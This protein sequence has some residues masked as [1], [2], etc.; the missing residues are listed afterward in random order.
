MEK[1]RLRREGESVEKEQEKKDKLVD[2]NEKIFD[3]FGNEVVVEK[4][5]K[6]SDKEKKREIKKLEKLLREGKKKGILTDTEMQ[7]IEEKLDAL[8]DQ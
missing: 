6:L 5:V 4:E 3:S 1:G 7:E 2:K 8:K